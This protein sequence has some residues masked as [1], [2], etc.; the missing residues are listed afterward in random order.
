LQ[1]DAE[2]RQLLLVFQS[3]EITEY[4]IYK[5]LAKSI[6]S[7]ENRAI[8]EKIAE[9]E[10]FR[11]RFFEMTGLSL[12]IATFSFIIGYFIRSALGIEI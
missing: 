9:D 7:P 12:T 1:I 10:P 6:K 11:R 8:L 3:N 5:R 4:H 2:L